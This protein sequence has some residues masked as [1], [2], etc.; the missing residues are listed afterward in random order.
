[1]HTRALMGQGKLAFQITYRDYDY[2]LFGFCL[3]VFWLL[4]VFVLK[5]VT[6]EKAQ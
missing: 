3:L 4:F 6:E 1:M 5:I 2:I